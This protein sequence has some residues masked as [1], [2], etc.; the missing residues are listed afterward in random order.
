MAGSRT[1]QFV[2]TWL[3]GQPTPLLVV[4][5]RDPSAL[6]GRRAPGDIEWCTGVSSVGDLPIR[7][8][9][10][11]LVFDQ[12][13]AMEARDAEELLARLRA[14]CARVTVLDAD[15]VL[16]AKTLIGLGYIE[17]D[18]SAADPPIRVYDP[19]IDNERREWNDAG[20][21]ANPENFDRYRW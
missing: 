20:D 7:Y 14:L 8:F 18:R 19:A 9:E 17:R 11:G 4:T 2:R 3:A 21:W 1:D 16:D 12:L 5:R 6:A 13:E 15:T 10:S